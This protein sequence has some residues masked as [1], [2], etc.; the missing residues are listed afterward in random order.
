[1]IYVTHD[2]TEAMTM[3][4]RIAVF[5]HGTLEQVGAPARRSTIGR[6][7]VSS[8]EFVGDSNFLAGTLDGAGLG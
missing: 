7:L 2:Q 6:R 5:N 3:S 4:D 8:G 1:M